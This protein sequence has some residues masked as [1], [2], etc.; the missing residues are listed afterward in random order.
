MPNSTIPQQIT[1]YLARPG[2]EPMTAKTLAKRLGVRKKNLPEFQAGLEEL[3]ASGAVREGKNGLLRPAAMTG[4][5]AGLV[6]RTSSGNGYLI[7][8]DKPPG[9]VDGDIFIARRDLADAHTGDEVLVRV[10]SRR[11]RGVQRCGRV[12]EVLER[13]TNVFVGTYFERE[14][15]GYVQVDGSVFVDP[16]YVGDPGAKGARPEDKVVIEMLRFPSHVQGGEAVLTRVLGP[17]GEPGVDLQSILHEFGLTQEFP[18]DVL[19]EARGQADRFDEAKLADR[20]DLTKETIVTI[21]PKT[22]RDFDDAIS[23]KRSKDGHWHLGVHIADVSHFVPEG[24]A[25]D[26]EA[27]K[28]GNSV[29]LPQMVIP[30]LPEVLSNGLA[31]LQQGKVRFVKSAFIEFTHEGVPVHTSFANSAIKVSRRFAYEDVLPIVHDPER[32]RTRVSAKVRQLLAMMHELAMLLRRRRFAAGALEMD[33]PEVDLDFDKQ[34]RVVGVHETENDESHQIIEEF[35]LA[36]NMAVA[37]E[38]EDRGLPFM[39]RVH[40]S[41]DETKLRTFAEFVTVLGFPLKHYQ[42]RPDLQALLK[43]VQGKP[44]EHAVNYALLRSM[45]PAV[46][47]GEALGHYALAVEDY[48][49]FTSPIRRYPDLTIHRLLDA[50]I[51]DNPAGRVL[52]LIELA[53]LGKHCSTTERRADDAERELTKIKLLTYMADRIGEELDAIITGVERFGI[54]CKGIEI[55]AEGLIHISMVSIDDYFYHDPATYS[56][57]GRSTGRQ[58]RLGDKVRVRVAHVDVDRRELDYQIVQPTSRVTAESGRQQRSR[59]EGQTA[60]KQG[61]RRKTD[62]KKPKGR[63][64]RR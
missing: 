6:K 56:L 57:I 29:Y 17:R 54:F 25:L 22:A 35:M 31:S 44:V 33:I 23:L 60:A 37:R 12:E 58:Y 2:Y 46:Y 42:S 8:H 51:S 9:A 32:F 30:M 36:A 27:R 5:I 62:G 15:Q 34:G 7:P 21:D 28:R 61:G 64:G 49:H 26:I 47:T 24:S 39:R 10:L 55:P 59:R 20:L 4:L 1:D 50:V 11:H 48:C 18:D 52:S 3:V 38:L 53:K 16:V 63:K 45:K 13:S 43:K 40:G 14:E 41:P 19:D